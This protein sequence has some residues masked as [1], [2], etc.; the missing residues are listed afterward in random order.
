MAKKLISDDRDG[1][2]EVELKMQIG[3]NGDYY[4][5]LIDKDKKRLDFQ[6]AMSGGNST[7]Q[8]A[9]KAFLLLFEALNEE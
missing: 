9:R 5:S 7:N 2:N 6:F 8:K 4:L 1:S 3:G